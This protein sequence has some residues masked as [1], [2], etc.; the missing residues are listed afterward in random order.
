MGVT[1]YTKP[2]CSRC[3]KVKEALKQNDVAFVEYTIGEDIT[4][5]KTLELF[6]GA[7]I[8][9]IVTINGTWIGG[10]DEILKILAEGQINELKE[11]WERT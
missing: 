9:P 11:L 6:P 7:K 8:L 10:R 2:D 5:E 1:L 3:V 4:R